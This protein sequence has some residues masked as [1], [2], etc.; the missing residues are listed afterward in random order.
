MDIPV[1]FSFV[2]NHRLFC[3]WLLCKVYISWAN[4]SDFR[5]GHPKYVLSKGMPPQNAFNSCF[6]PFR[7][8]NNLPRYIY[9]YKKWIS[10]MVNIGFLQL[11][12][13][14]RMDKSPNNDYNNLKTLVLLG[15]SQVTTEPLQMELFGPDFW[16]CHWKIATSVYH[17]IVLDVLYFLILLNS[18]DVRWCGPQR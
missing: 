13:V 7:N 6:G 3:S 12:K 18:G 17:P 14:G 4:H 9:C 2:A 1:H 16:S 5:R 15:W 8:Y 10:I 11:Q